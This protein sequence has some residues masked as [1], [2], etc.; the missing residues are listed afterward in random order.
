MGRSPA[1]IAWSN[2]SSERRWRGYWICQAWTLWHGNEV[3]KV[4]QGWAQF[5]VLI[6]I[7]LQHREICT[8]YWTNNKRREGK[9]GD[10]WGLAFHGAS[11]RKPGGSRRVI[12]RS[13]YSSS[14][15]NEVCHYIMMLFWCCKNSLFFQLSQLSQRTVVLVVYRRAFRG[16]QIASEPSKWPIMVTLVRPH[17]ATKLFLSNAAELRLKWGKGWG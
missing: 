10:W 15:C 5:A 11:V 6:P 14:R 8:T 7:C 2:F 12:P 17:D 1:R 16:V 13:I 9:R 4:S 3:H